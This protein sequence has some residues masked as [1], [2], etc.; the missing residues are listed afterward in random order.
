MEP[1]IHHRHC[2]C[3]AQFICHGECGDSR[4]TARSDDCWCPSCARENHRKQWAPWLKLCET[5]FGSD[6]KFKI[7]GKKS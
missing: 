7:E 4:K 5:R 3:G 6:S 1:Q 2:A